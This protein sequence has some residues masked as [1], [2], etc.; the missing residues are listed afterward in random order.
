MAT[1]RVKARVLIS[2]SSAL[3][4]IAM[5]QDIA[6]G[7]Q[8]GARFRNRVIMRLSRLLPLQAPPRITQPDSA[9]VLAVAD[10]S[11]LVPMAGSHV[12][13]LFAIRL[14]VNP[15]PLTGSH[16]AVSYLPLQAPPRITQPESVSRALRQLGEAGASC[17]DGLVHASTRGK[18][19]GVPV[20]FSMDHRLMQVRKLGQIVGLV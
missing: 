20:I 19:R 17:T 7:L 14:Q 12:A 13:I 5:A 16:V 18:T 11:T 2:G 1:E 6:L 8:V 3:R 9:S 15:V 10:H 4:L